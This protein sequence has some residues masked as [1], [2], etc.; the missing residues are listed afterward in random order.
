MLMITSDSQKHREQVAFLLKMIQTMRDEVQS[1]F[2]GIIQ[3]VKQL[4]TKVLDFVEKEEAAALE[5]LGSSIQQSHNWLLKLEADSIWLRTLLTNPSDQQF[6]QEFPRLKNFQDCMEPLMGTS[7]EEKQS[8]LQLPQTLAEL[9]SRLVGMG[10]GFINQL[11]LQGQYL[12]PGPLDT[13]CHSGAGT[14]LQGSGWG[15]FRASSRALPARVHLP[16]VTPPPGSPLGWAC[17]QQSPPSPQ[18]LK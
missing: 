7:W 16:Q 12:R 2:S 13:P 18:A 17:P 10:L 15:G 11:L 9:R 8:F 6:L 14:A 4:Q 3:E 5:K 1:C